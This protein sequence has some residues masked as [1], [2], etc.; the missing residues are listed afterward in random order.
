M[1][2]LKTE[3]HKL[4][5]MKPVS[6]SSK[7]E[8]YKNCAIK[9]TKKKTVDRKVLN[10]R[11]GHNIALWELSKQFLKSWSCLNVFFSAKNLNEMK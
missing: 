8:K 3:V 1:F 2:C 6:I 7:K 9:K 10:P 5:S 11:F 4:R